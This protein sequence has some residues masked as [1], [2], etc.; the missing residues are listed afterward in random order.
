[1]I[2]LTLALI[3]A[4][5]GSA[6]AAGINFDGSLETNIEWRRD[7]EGVVTTSPS[8]ELGLNFGLDTGSDKTRAV[9]EFGID[10]E[11][12]DGLNLQLDGSSLV[13]NKVYIETD[14]AF[15]HGGPEATTRFG[16]LDI[17]YGPYATVKN[18]SGIGVKGME[19]G[20][21]KVNGFYGVPGQDTGY[22]TGINAIV[23]LDNVVAGSSVIKDNNAV[24]I[25]VD[26]KVAPMEGL[27]VTGSGA[28]QVELNQEVVEETEEKS[29][30]HMVIAGAEYELTDNMSIRGG[31][32]SIT[33]GWK[34]GYVAEKNKKDQGQNWIH[35]ADRKDK[36]FYAGLSTDYQGV[37]IAADYDQMF[38]EAVLSAGTNV[39]DFDLN[40]E[41]VLAVNAEGISTSSTTLDVEREFAIMDGLDLTANYNGEWAPV[42]GITHTIGADTKIG[43]IPAIKGLGLNSEVTVSDRET[44]GYAVGAEFTAPNGLE[45]GIEHVGGTFADSGV[46]LGT[47]AKAGIAVEF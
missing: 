47:I 38:E 3:V 42:N 41:T 29:L 12:E 34:P 28:T 36:G 25:V 10:E 24:H 22:T 17:N 45:L 14:G 9:V 30:N 31:F 11:N 43:L 33:N 20:P 37:A 26:G 6:F 4:M 39:N 1:M 21:V 18:Q 44:I 32:K 5:T 27:V 35:E 8:T 2:V 40:V 23:G 16:S 15:W 7:G 46:K 19:V 13:L